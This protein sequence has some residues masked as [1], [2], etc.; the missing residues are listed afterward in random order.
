MKINITL[1]ALL[2]SLNSFGQDREYEI[3]NT[4]YKNQN[5]TEAVAIG[6]KLLQNQYGS[7]SP[8]LN[9]FTTYLVGD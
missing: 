2:L 3:V 8:F 4:N 6:E 7:L 9:M 1:F 5:Y